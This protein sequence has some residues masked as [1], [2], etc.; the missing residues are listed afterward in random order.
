ML[1]NGNIKF[2]YPKFSLVLQ[3]GKFKLFVWS[4][5][6]LH[7]T[8]YNKRSSNVHWKSIS[9]SARNLYNI[10]F[11]T[12]GDAVAWCSR[13][14]LHQLN[15][16][17]L[18]LKLFRGLF[19]NDTIQNIEDFPLSPADRWFW[20][21]NHHWVPTEPLELSEDWHSSQSTDDHE[22]RWFHIENCSSSGTCEL[23]WSKGC[24]KMSQK[25]SWTVF[26]LHLGT[27][28]I[29]NI[30]IYG[31]NDVQWQNAT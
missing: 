3:N 17:H 10:V 12:R 15:S 23:H 5:S 27:T 4:H 30:T 24:D 2:I 14:I 28:F 7:P 31:N 18:C 13:T 22:G 8:F 9:N 1:E 26:L 25:T 19:T 6:I 29:T 21:W 11:D 20:T 16:F